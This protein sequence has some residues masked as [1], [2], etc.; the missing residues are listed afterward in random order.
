MFLL[1]EFDGPSHVGE[2]W[3]KL[4]VTTCFNYSPWNKYC[5]EPPCGQFDPTKARLYDILGEIYS[6]MYDAFGQPD[7]FHM[8]GD[9]VGEECWETS[10]DIQNWIQNHKLKP[11]TNGFMELWGYFQRNALERMDRIANENTTIIL[12]T[13][14]MTG[15]KYVEKYLDKD[16]YVIQVSEIE[17]DENQRFNL[18]LSRIEKNF[19]TDQKHNKFFWKKS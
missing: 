17:E 12:W 14:T 18:L 5:P 2:G 4:N 1:P 13:S 10:K 16:R 6:E 7:R 8:G 11:D 15:K 9:E 3:Q 19:K